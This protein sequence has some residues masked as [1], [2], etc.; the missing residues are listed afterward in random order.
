M[1]RGDGNGPINP[2]PS[3][4]PY[5]LLPSKFHPALS[6]PA[7]PEERSPQPLPSHIS[8]PTGTPGQPVRGQRPQCHHAL[9]LSPVGLRRVSPPGAHALPA[10]AGRAPGYPEREPAHP[11]GRGLSAQPAA[12]ATLPVPAVSHRALLHAG[13]GAPLPGPPG[14]ARPR[15]GQPHLLPGLHCS[16]ADVCGSGRGR[17]LPAGRY[18]LWPLRGH[19][20]PA[21][22]HG[23]GGTWAVHAAGPGL[24]LPRGTGGVRG[25][26]GGR[27]Q[28]AFLRLPPASAFLRRHHSAAAPGLHA[29]LRGGAAS[30]GRL[31]GVAAAALAAH[32]GLP[33]RYRRRP[34]PHA[35]PTRRAQGCLHLCLAPGRHLPPLQ[36]LHL[37]V[38]AAQ[39]QLLPT[40][41]SHAGADLHQRHATALPA[42]LQP[43]Q[44][45]NHGRHPLGAEPQGRIC[46]SHDSRQGRGQGGRLC[47]LNFPLSAGV[48]T[49]DA[50][51]RAQEPDS[52]KIIWKSVP[53]RES[54]NSFPILR[55]FCVE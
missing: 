46:V 54:P 15:P 4:Q 47:S 36:L 14:L 35:L 18:G 31:P 39:G 32:P 10:A 6:S 16:G 55:Q 17:V 42:H 52:E 24:L 13:S 50:T 2:P 44:W 20:T 19:L 53:L 25:A 3:L 8:F 33:W 40:A 38:H 51:G 37:H 49:E 22:L 43:A 1:G 29:E 30:A 26:H 5:S 21:V 7:A 9:R 23:C 45:Q 11:G 28:P 34:E 48:C 27:L 12:H 41:G